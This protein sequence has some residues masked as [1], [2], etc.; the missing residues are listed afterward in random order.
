M[1]ISLCNNGKLE[2][3]PRHKAIGEGGVAP[4]PLLRE[5]EEEE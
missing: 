5:F 3:L 2:I 4:S 1:K